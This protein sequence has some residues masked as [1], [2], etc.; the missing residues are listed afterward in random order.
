MGLI[1]INDISDGTDADANDINS[2]M[3]TLKNVINGNIDS[4]NIAAQGVATSNIATGAVTT[5]KVAS[6]AVTPPK[7]TNPYKFSAYRAA[8]QSPAGGVIQ[9]DTENFDTNNNF[10]ITTNKGRY[11]IPVSGFYQFNV[12]SNQ[13]VTAAPQDPQIILMKNGTTQLGYD[14]F[15]NMYAGASEGGVSI[16]VI[17]QLTAGD[18]VEVYGG[19]PPLA[20]STPGRNVFSGFLVSET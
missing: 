7:W 5:T 12:V 18:Y 14:H 9:Y 2:R 1:T 4:A 10:D 16:S 11:T 20:V 15:V 13:L 19:T 6:A 17:A 8:A 3:A